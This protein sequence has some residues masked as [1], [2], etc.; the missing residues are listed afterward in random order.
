MYFAKFTRTAQIFDVA[1][2]QKFKRLREPNANGVKPLEVAKR[3]SLGHSTVYRVLNKIE[4]ELRLINWA[5]NVKRDCLPVL[6]CPLCLINNESDFESGL[7]G[8]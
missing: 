5:V 1:P 8:N 6:W 4:N 3:L 2:A 7:L